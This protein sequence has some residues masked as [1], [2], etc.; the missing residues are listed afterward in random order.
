VSS[1]G[2]VRSALVAVCAAILDA[3]LAVVL[4]LTFFIVATGGGVYHVFGTRISARTV[5]NP[6]LIAQLILL[7]RLTWLRAVPLFR[8]PALGFEALSRNARIAGYRLATALRSLTASRARILLLSMI[9]LFTLVK[10]ANAYFYPGFVSGDDV[11]V[12]EMTFASLFDTDWTLWNIRSPLYPFLIIYPIQAL[13]VAAGEQDTATLVFAGRCIVAVMS[14][15]AVWLTYRLGAITAGRGYGVLAAFVFG[16][17]RLHVTFGGSELP[18][19]VSVVFIAAACLCLHMSP[20][21]RRAIL[22]GALLAVGSA[23]RFSELI[24]VVPASLDLLSRRRYRDIV[25]CG[26]TF[27]VVSVVCLGL[28]DRFFWVKRF[29]ASGTSSATRS[30]IGCHREAISRRSITCSRCRSGRHCPP[31]C[32]PCS[33]VRRTAAGSRSGGSCPCAY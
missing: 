31:W 29:S 33:D 3:A 28:V 10:L 17:H 24:F 16:M 25:V 8:M 27:I 9:A 30:S 20:N 13:L 23:L 19:P 11:E 2:A 26:A 14:S 18:R 21:T 15:L 12:H 5:G 1:Q 6:L 32:S 4:V 22:A 7:L